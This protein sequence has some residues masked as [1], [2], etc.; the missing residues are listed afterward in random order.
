VG[1]LAFVGGALVL[2]AGVGVLRFEDLYSRMHAATKAPTLGALLIGV[3]GV[4][5]GTVIAYPISTLLPLGVYVPRLLRRL[6]RAAP[7]RAEGEAA[8]PVD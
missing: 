4:I 8:V 7:R 5:L 1:I 3:A 2:L 6:E